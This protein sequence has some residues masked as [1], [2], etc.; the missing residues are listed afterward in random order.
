MD[1]KACIEIKTNYI[2]HIPDNGVPSQQYVEAVLIPFFLK[3]SVHCNKNIFYY[4]KT[5][6]DEASGIYLAGIEYKFYR[7]LQYMSSYCA[8]VKIFEGIVFLMEA[9]FRTEDIRV[10]FSC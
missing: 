1:F 9:V 3:W 5:E 7:S 10:Y 8:F 2:D 6:Y 4:H